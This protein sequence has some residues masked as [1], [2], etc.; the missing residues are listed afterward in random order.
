MK[1]NKKWAL[2][3]VV[4]AI[5]AASIGYQACSVAQDQTSS[6]DLKK[7][8]INF[9]EAL[10]KVA[11]AN[12]EKAHDANTAAPEAI[13]S[14]VVRSLQN[15]VAMAQA[16]VSMLTDE[17]TGDSPYVVSSKASL[18][19]AQE[20][21]KQAMEVNGKTPGTYNKAELNRRQALVELAQARLGV[22]QQLA[23]A[24]PEERMQWEL[25]LL[26]EDVHNLR[27]NVQLLQYHN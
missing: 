27:F 14:T 11:Q 15:D 20:N 7:A 5:A 6:D 21:L 10:V 12:L 3:V 22:C 19:S 24:P 18:A 16:R 4:A 25:L 9:A 17:T 26:E 8:K 1:T 23:K 2:A 13:P